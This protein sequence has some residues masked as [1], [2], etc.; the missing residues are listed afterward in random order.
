LCRRNPTT[1]NPEVAISGPKQGIN[2]VH[3][4]VFINQA[5]LPQVRQ[6][7]TGNYHPAQVTNLVFEALNLII[8]KGT[9]EEL[10]F[11]N[12]YLD[13]FYVLRT[14]PGKA[15]KEN[16]ANAKSANLISA[17]FEAIMIS[18]KFSMSERH[19]DTKYIE[20]K[21]KKRRKG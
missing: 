12:P 8:E 21:K 6:V 9:G 5:G 1:N 15:G 11:Y 18:W 20:A 16:M 2:L 13:G 3:A 7:S 19:P 10:D 14:N 4:E 17:D